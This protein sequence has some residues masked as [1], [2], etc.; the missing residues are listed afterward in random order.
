MN[1]LRSTVD[2]VK[3]PPGGHSDEIGTDPH[4]RLVV[5]LVEEREGILDARMVLVAVGDEKG[6]DPGGEQKSDNDTCGDF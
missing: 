1:L 4:P 2:P 5:E 6:G 3:N